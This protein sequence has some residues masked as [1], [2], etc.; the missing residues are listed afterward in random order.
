MSVHQP[1]GWEHQDDLGALGFPLS[2]EPQGVWV[3]LPALA[4]QGADRRLRC[5]WRQGD[6][7]EVCRPVPAG[8]SDAWDFLP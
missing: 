4:S 7:A 6:V 3:L 2:P 5:R 1:D 8:V